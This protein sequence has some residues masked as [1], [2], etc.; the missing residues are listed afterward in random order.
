MGLMDHS[1]YYSISIQAQGQPVRGCELYN[2]KNLDSQNLYH[3]I[4][5]AFAFFSN[6]C[7]M[8]E[9]HAAWK[10]ACSSIKHCSRLQSL[11]VDRCGVSDR[12]L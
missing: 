8:M 7:S 12:E 5:S 1:L 10:H 4:V 6:S 11:L 3:T 2:S 9:Q